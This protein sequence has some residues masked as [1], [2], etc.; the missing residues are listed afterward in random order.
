MAITRPCLRGRMGSTTY[1]EVTMT[2]RELTNSVRPARETD[3]WASASID[4]RIQREVNKGRV[5]KT[6]VPY[7]AQHPDRFFGSFIVLA[8]PGGIEFESLGDIVEGLSAAY[9]SQAGDIGF[10]TFTSGELI[11]LDGQH[12]LVAFREVITGGPEL[13]P[14][15]SQVGDDQVCVLVLEEESAEK[16]RR[17]FNKVNRH[18]KPTGRSD[19]IITSEDDGYALVTRRLL[20][21]SIEAPLAARQSEE[22]SHDLVEWGMTTLKQKSEKLTTISAVYETVQDVLSIN[23]GFAGFSEKEN[24]VAPDDNTLNRAYDVVSDWW[25]QILTLQAFT[26]ALSDPASIPSTRFDNEHSHTLLL[27]PVGQMALVKGLTRAMTYSKGEVSLKTLLERVDR[28]DFSATPSCI[29]RDTIVRADGR[30]VARRE[31]FE[32]AGRLVCYMILPDYVTEEF[33]QTLYEDW[34]KARGKDPYSDIDTLEENERPVDL[35]EPLSL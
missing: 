14:Y 22:R 25:E 5:M 26:T 32:L 34:N 13:G 18:A 31:A 2:A 23:N 35:P 1:Y 29:W 19:N 21:S 11:A 6:I 27:R 10:L 7:L 8:K 30:M 20:D 17:I 15:W 16:T 4:E 28:V 3:A 9:R 33:T 12:R 24:P